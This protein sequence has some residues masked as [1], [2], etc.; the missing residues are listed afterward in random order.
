MLILGKICVCNAAAAA[1]HCDGEMVDG[2]WRPRAKNVEQ[3][4]FVLIGRHLGCGSRVS[5]CVCVS[6]LVSKVRAFCTNNWNSWWVR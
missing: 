4:L 6:C 3:K 1:M 2:R 5:V